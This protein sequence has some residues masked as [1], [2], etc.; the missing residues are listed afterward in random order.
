MPRP[1]FVLSHPNHELAVL[2]HLQRLRPHLLVLTDGGAAERVEQTRAQLARLGLLSDA[3]FLSHPEEAFYEALRRRDA[4]FFR[5]V[6]G[7]VAERVAEVSPA[8]VWCDAVEHYNPTHDL[9]LPLVL[10]ALADRPHLP[11]REIPLVHQA[12]GGGEPHAPRYVLQRFPPPPEPGEEALRLA[13]TEVEA[14]RRARDEAYPS[15]AAQLG[16]LLTS[17]PREVLEVEVTRAVPRRATPALPTPDGRRVLRYEWRGRLRQTRGEVAEALTF[18][19]A[20]RPALEG[21]GVRVEPPAPPE[22]ASSR[23]ARHP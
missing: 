6:A 9:S 21:L 22:L 17:A 1:L 23:T 18:E 14:K 8:S 2:G 15:L 4:G 5:R 16:G 20:M 13:P 3:R 12:P 11:V 10:R 19:G 7:Q